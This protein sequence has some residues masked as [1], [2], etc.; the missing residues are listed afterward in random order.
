M[1]S[2]GT[3]WANWSGLAESRPASVLTPSDT[4]E[5]V[6]AVVA[7]RR[8]G[9]TVKMVGSGHSFTDIAVGNGLLLRPDRLSGRH[10]RRP[11]RDDRDRARR[12]PAARPQRTALRPRP[13]AA[14]HGRH[15]PADRG[16]RD[17]DRHPRVG[18]PVGVAVL[19]GRRLRAGDRGRVVVTVSRSRTPTCSPPPR[20]GSG[21][22]ASSPRSRSW[23][24]PSSG[25]PRPRRRCPG[26]TWSTA[27]TSSSRTT[28]T[29][30][31]TGSPGPT[32]PW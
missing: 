5:V 7:A 1:A 31:C 14:Q 19:A 27:S 17:L 2:S 13:G 28:T 8:Q 3:T 15:R 10:R 6:D 4:G 22:S 29:S 20:S 30:T 11:R 25:S 21:H 23:S 12:H 24:S 32:G 26:A 16:R 18:W 9:L